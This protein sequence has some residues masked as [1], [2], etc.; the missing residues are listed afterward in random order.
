MLLHWCSSLLRV[1]RRNLASRFMGLRN[2]VPLRICVT[3]S[4]VKREKSAAT[5]DWFQIVQ[6]QQCTL[7]SFGCM[8]DRQ[9]LIDIVCRTDE[10]FTNKPLP[11]ACSWQIESI[12]LDSSWCVL[13]LRS[14]RCRSRLVPCCSRSDHISKPTS[15]KLAMFPFRLTRPINLGKIQHGDMGNE[16]HNISRYGL[17]H[18]QPKTLKKSKK[19]LSTS[20]PHQLKTQYLHFRFHANYITLFYIGRFQKKL[21]NDSML[22]RGFTRNWMFNG[23]ICYVVYCRYC[24]FTLGGRSSLFVTVDLM[25][26]ND[27]SHVLL[28][29]AWRSMLRRLIMT[30][31]TED[32]GSVALSIYRLVYI[33]ASDI[34]WYHQNRYKRKK[35]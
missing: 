6:N 18:I 32:L 7:L 25:V 29:L 31:F 1:P 16:G 10:W 12:D 23:N 21:A 14:V 8:N 19:K 5:S 15:I 20:L 30:K 26:R 24:V 17:R 35:H 2:H 11:I 13:N 3:C 22:S 4:G 34:L 28:S 27:H 33:I 9:F